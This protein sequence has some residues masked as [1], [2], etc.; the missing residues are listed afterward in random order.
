MTEKTNVLAAALVAACA[1]AT[2]VEKTSRNQHM[3]Y[4]YASA[5]AVIAEAKAAMNANGL[6]LMAMSH[7]VELHT[8]ETHWGMLQSSWRLLHS[9]GDYL[10]LHS[11]WPIVVER[12]RPADKALA[13]ART[14]SLSYLLR[15]LLQLPRV[16]EGVDMDDASRDAPQRDAPQRQQQPLRQH[17]QQAAS[18]PRP[19]DPS[20]A[21]L[22]ECAEILDTCTSPGSVDAAVTAMGARLGDL[23][24]PML[25]GLKLYAEAVKKRLIGLDLSQEEV[26]VVDRISNIKKEATK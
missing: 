26:K 25:G 12:G 13:S 14:A 15:D 21:L 23:P 8:S 11:T 7:N 4:M 10:D 6:T 17:V 1:A 24:K 22:R 20:I 5:E 16:E 19:A 9:S 2:G 18:T 3:R